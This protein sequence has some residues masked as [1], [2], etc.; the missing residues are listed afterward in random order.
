MYKN[1]ITIRPHLISLLVI[2]LIGVV[3]FLGIDKIF[4]Q[5]DEWLGLGGAIYRQETF[6]TMGSIKQVFNFQNRNE[7]T[8]FLP[9]TSIANH[10]LYNNFRLNTGAYGLLSLTILIICALLINSIVYK[11]TNSHLI[12]TITSLL[13]VTNNLAYQ[14]FTWIATMMPSLLT[15]L[16]FLLGLYFL[17][18]YNEKQKSFFSGIYVKCHIVFIF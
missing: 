5:Q 6:G 13:W 15:V 16:F 9:I 12:S 18:V 4:F 3:T 17:L 2:I 8:R 14:A 7:S 10:F 11:L 1:K